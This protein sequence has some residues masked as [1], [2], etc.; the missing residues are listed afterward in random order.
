[1]STVGLVLI[2][3]VVLILV[4]A[5]PTWQYS[6]GWGYGPSGL[7]GIVLLVLLVLYLTGRL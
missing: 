5:F 1:M 3:L 4:G 2:I 6:A 7:I